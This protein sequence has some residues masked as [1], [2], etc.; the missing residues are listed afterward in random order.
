[1]LVGGVLFITLHAVSD[2]GVTGLLGAKLATFGAQHD[3]GISYVLYLTTYAVDSVGDV[4]GSL[5]ALAAGLLAMR[6]GAQPRW[7]C[8][9]A[10][11]V[12]GLF[13]L[14]G[15]GLGGLIATYGLVLDLIGFVLLLV[16]VLASGI[17]LLR[18]ANRSEPLAR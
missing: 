2:I 14:Q 17:I 13:F 6:S 18:S 10:T 3:P 15:F 11:L 1:M 5:F 7:L 4:F 12:A 8:W 9:I 16:F